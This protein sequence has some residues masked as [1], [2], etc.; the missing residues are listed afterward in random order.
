LT[1]RNLYQFKS[2]SIPDYEVLMDEQ[3]FNASQFYFITFINLVLQ[4]ISLSSLEE[5]LGEL[6]NIATPITNTEFRENNQAAYA[7]LIE[8][9]LPLFLTGK[10]NAGYSADKSTSFTIANETYN[11]I[12]QHSHDTG[13][14]YPKLDMPQET[15]YNIYDFIRA[16]IKAGRRYNMFK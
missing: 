9:A 4:S 1:F 15:K 3:L 14:A 5:A 13:L 12:F 11:L 16:A 8:I 7:W 10:Q 2:Y 6:A